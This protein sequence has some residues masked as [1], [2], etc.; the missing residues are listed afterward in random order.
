MRAPRTLLFAFLLCPLALFLGGLRSEPS[1]FTF[2]LLGDRTGEAQPG[3][4]EQVWR[5]TAAENPAFVV[6]AGDLIEGLNDDTAS[7]QWRAFQRTLQPYGRFP[8]HSAPG[9]HDVW[10]PASERLFEKYTARPLHHSFDYGAAH[11][12]ILDNARSDELSPA[13]LAYL[14]ADLQ[15]HAS[16]PLKFIVS[17]RPS[18]IIP[19]AL[20]NPDFPLHQIARRHGVQYVVAGHVHQLLRFELE[21]ITYLS[22]PSAGGHLRASA[23]YSAGWFFGHTLAKVNGTRVDFR[24]EELKPPHGEGRITQLSDWGMLGLNR[25]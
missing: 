9:N 2:A 20:K 4:W 23:Q 11:F 3:V 22:L 5:E 12:T 10:S 17:H 21:G 6:C 16:Q 7:D 18:W 15:A 1:A 13:E 14:E 19:V 8:F 25:K 24:I